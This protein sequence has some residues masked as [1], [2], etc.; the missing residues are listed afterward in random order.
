MFET[1]KSLSPNKNIFCFKRIS[2]PSPTKIML[3]NRK[4]SIHLYNQNYAWDTL[5]IDWNEVNMTFNSK[6]VNL[7]RFVTIKLR[8]KFRIRHMMKKEPLLIHIMLNKEL[9]GSHWLPTLK[10]LYKTI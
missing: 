4:R 1:G 3:P 2:G 7:P 10:K 5:E 9:L 6:N 8:N